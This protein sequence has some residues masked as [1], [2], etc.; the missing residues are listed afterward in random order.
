MDSPSVRN[1]RHRGAGDRGDHASALLM[2]NTPRPLRSPD[3][4][5]HRRWKNP[6]RRPHRN[7][8]TLPL[9]LC[10][11]PPLYSGEVDERSESGGGGDLC[12]F[13]VFLC[14][15]VVYVCP[16]TL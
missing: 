10:A 15:R 12:V 13:V 3:M 11:P 4:V 1:N 5:D 8:M 7:H 6:T 16:V 2:G 14:P 9:L